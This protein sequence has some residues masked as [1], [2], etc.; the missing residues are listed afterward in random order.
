VLVFALAVMLVHC[1]GC[2]EP[3]SACCCMHDAIQVMLHSEC[4]HLWC[5]MHTRLRVCVRLW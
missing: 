5:A 3:M 2:Y 4:M 1:V